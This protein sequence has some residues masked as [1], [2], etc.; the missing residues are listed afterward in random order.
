M[1]T[2][3][4]HLSERLNIALV[5]RYRLERE[6]GSGAMGVVFLA[7]DVRHG[8]PV[9]IKVLR[10][11]LAG[12]IGTDRFIREI[13]TV[14]GLQHPN[15]VPLFDSGEADGLLYYVM[16]YIEG[17]SLRGRLGRERQLPIADT[18]QIARDVAEALG[19]A[20]GRGV[21]HRDIK[22]ENILLSGG[23][24][25]VA[26]FGIAS[27]I[28]AA[29]ETGLTETGMVVGTPLYMAP[30]QMSG[31]PV[32][33]RAD[34]YALSCVVYEMFAGEPPYT[35][36]TPQSVIAKR[37]ADPVPS[38]RR[39]RDAV[40]DCA[41]QALM[42]A[43]AKIPADRFA[44][45][46]AFADALTTAAPVPARS[47]SIAVL[48]FLNLSADPENEYF[49]DGIT[50]EIIAQ[51]SRIGALKVIS[52]T[53]VMA[54]KNREQGLREIGA[55]LGVGTLLEGSVRRAGNRVRIVAQLIDA[56]T[57]EHLWVET[58]DRELTD[59]FA[60][61]SDVALHIAAALK[62]ELSPDEKARLAKEPTS[63]VDAYHLYL[64]GR[65]CYYRFTQ[66]GIRKSLEY[67]RKAIELDPNYA[68]AYAGIA[69]SYVVMGM[70][71][72]STALRPAEAHVKAKEAVAK[73]FELNDRV[74]EA[75]SVLGLLSFVADFD[76]IGAERAFKRAIDLNPSSAETYASY[77]LMLSALERYDEAI[78][79]QKKAQELDP[80]AAVVASDLVTT[81]L[82]AGR[83]DEALRAAKQLIELEP[84]FPMGHSTLG[85]ALLRKGMRDECLAELQK[86][87]AVSESDTMTL[88]QL[89]QAYALV[90]RVGEAR[91]VLQ[92]LEDLSRHR[93]VSPY[94][95][96]YIYTGLGERD[97]AIE[98]LEQAI[99][100]R[101]GGVYGI[102]GS[103][104]F[105][106]LRSHPRFADLLKRMNLS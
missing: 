106:T 8:R 39:L 95:L 88:A 90:D 51:L 62:A 56:E 46:V 100:Q 25:A 16:P 78:A 22:P 89:G 50:E 84:D 29:G 101:A 81:L 45:A 105:A 98:L 71:Y 69:Q 54:F 79:A 58:Y 17:E 103:F 64:Q 94:H 3:A 76:W 9:A 43:L 24:A 91:A 20:H 74:P 21:V 19:Y 36:P 93:Y 4:D 92:Q 49:T 102:K 28:S 12:S 57:D 66:E 32:D 70:G 52:R 80:L 73:A 31:G 99:E 2:V 72:G 65:H 30:E 53:S 82:R 68:R 10:P 60:I 77:G 61:Q 47:R 37:Q 38:V 1:A 55:R 85:W 18:V 11:G 83:D 67:F 42:K 26:D 6:L 35:G 14:A 34:V 15:I 13:R 104:L 59:I 27:A 40:P 5:S 41:E 97:K 86:A 96:A 48:P 87:V 33:G 7:H 75:H 23:R 44:S 63:D